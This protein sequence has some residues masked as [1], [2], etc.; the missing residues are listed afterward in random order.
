M[1]N[2]QAILDQ[3]IEYLEQNTT[4]LEESELRVPIRHF[5]SEERAQ[6]EIEVMRSKPLVVAHHSEIPDP[7]SFITRDVLGTPLLIVRQKDR[8]VRANINIC[9]HRGG[10]VECASEGKKRVFTCNYHGWT[11]DRDGSL[12]HIPYAQFFEPLDRVDHGL[13]QVQVEE[14]HG[15]IWVTLEPEDTPI[16]VQEYLGEDME[17][18]LSE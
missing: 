3:L 4:H 14:R 10:T 15:F 18:R 7:G 2:Q 8:S 12:R 6:D 17:H 5:T 9:K 1:S 11:Y 13:T 16:S